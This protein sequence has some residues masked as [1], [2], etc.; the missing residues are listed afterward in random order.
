MEIVFKAVAGTPPADTV[1]TARVIDAATSVEGIYVSGEASVSIRIGVPVG[2]EV[3][4][5]DLSY[6]RSVVTAVAVIALTAGAMLLWS[7]R[8]L[9]PRASNAPCNAGSLD[10]GPQRYLGPIPLFLS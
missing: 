5:P 4:P 1:D 2:G 8:R 6:A 3:M 10:P 9:S 7:L